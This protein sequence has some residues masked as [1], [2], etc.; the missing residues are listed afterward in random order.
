MA[1]V[2]TSGMRYLRMLTNSMIAGA[3]GAAYLAIVVLQLNPDVPL[4]SA[5]PWWWFVTLAL[6]YGVL[7][8][9]TCYALIVAR[10]FFA[11][12][13]LSPGWAS[14]RMLAWLAAALAAGAAALMWLNVRGFETTLGEAA[15]RR[16]IIGAIATSAAA[17]ILL[18]I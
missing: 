18:V 8:A 3:L 9:I 10:E 6:T 1:E 17:V 5:T 13:A 15:A 11:M 16:M 14:V 4:A 12:G 2:Y 7:I